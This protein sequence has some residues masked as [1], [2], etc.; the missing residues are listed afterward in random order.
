MKKYLFLLFTLALTAFTTR[1]DTTANDFEAEL[2][3]LEARELAH[4]EKEDALVEK[5]IVVDSVSEQNAALLKK[6]ELPEPPAVPI[7]QELK[8]VKKTRRIPSR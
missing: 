2:R 3:Q 7:S 4:D 5:T 1:A 6:S 8:A